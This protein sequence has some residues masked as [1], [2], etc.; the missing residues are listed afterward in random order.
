MRNSA[1]DMRVDESVPV[2]HTIFTEGYAYTVQAPSTVH[3]CTV[4]F[5][6][7]FLPFHGGGR[8]EDLVSQ[9]TSEETSEIKRY[10]RRLPPNHQV[11]PG[12]DAGLG[13]RK[14]HVRGER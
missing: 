13:A 7:I 8:W 6:R 4:W 1:S 14:G 3:F 2:R 10:M 5:N 11:T 9:I 12:Q